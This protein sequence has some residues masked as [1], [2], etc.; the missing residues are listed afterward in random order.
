MRLGIVHHRIQPSSP[1]QDGAHERMHRTLQAST[2][3]PPAKNRVGQQKKFDA[4]IDEFNNLRPHESLDDDTPASRYRP[5]PR[6]FPERIHKPEYPGHCEHRRVSNAG[7]FRFGSRQ[8][9]LSQALG[10]DV[11]GLE[12]I[13]DGLWN[14]LF[15]STLL[16]RFDERTGKISGADFRTD[17][18]G[19]GWF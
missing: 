10:G 2:T 12:E 6:P 13:D 3:R 4:F 14:I 7:C 18:G 17:A 11:I 16:G 9:F 8:V 1:Q 5:S 15:C 19:A